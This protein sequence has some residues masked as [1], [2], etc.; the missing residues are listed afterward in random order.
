VPLQ[1]HGDVAT[2]ARRGESVVFTTDG[3][4]DFLS[5]KDLRKTT[6]EL[7]FQEA[8]GG[9]FSPNGRLFGVASRMGYVRFWETDTWKEQV[10]LR[11]FLSEV[12]SLA[13]SPDGRRLATGGGFDPQAALKLWDAENW[14]RDER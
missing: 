9:T 12:T 2:N 7:D 5:L 1:P 3:R 10:T 4:V 13:F 8:N 6:L 11:G 14:L